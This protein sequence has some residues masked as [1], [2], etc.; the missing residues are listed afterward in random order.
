MNVSSQLE[1]CAGLVLILLFICEIVLGVIIYDYYDFKLHGV[2]QTNFTLTGN[3]IIKTDLETHGIFYIPVCH[4]TTPY[5][6]CYY[7]CSNKQISIYQ[8]AENY[9]TIHCT[10]NTTF[11]GYIITENNQ[12][13]IP[14]PNDTI[15]NELIAFYIILLI[16]ALC[17]GYISY[18]VTYV[19]YKTIIEENE[20]QPNENNE[21]NNNN[22][23]DN[24]NSITDE[25]N[26]SL[27][28]F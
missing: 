7:T 16:G 26:I 4:A 25:A 28:Y 19:D 1:G 8:D 18:S 12:C 6:E 3:H 17:C 10:N 24:T 5:G 22:K 2:H 15:H 21:N 23:N 11:A 13:V 20:I 27:D 9:A 14:Y